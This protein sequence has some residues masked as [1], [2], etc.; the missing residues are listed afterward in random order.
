MP[1]IGT[2][3][4]KPAATNFMMSGVSDIPPDNIPRTPFGRP[5]VPDV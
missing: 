4:E 3:C 1:G 5:V 2:N